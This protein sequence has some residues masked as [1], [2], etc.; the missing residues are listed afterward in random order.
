MSEDKSNPYVRK[1]KRAIEVLA[2]VIRSHKVAHKQ[3]TISNY[4]LM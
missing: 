2:E 4:L 3:T 1:D